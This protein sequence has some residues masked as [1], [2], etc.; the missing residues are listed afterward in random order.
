MNYYKILK[1]YRHIE[2]PRIKLLGILALHLSGRRYINVF[3]DPVLACNL[4]CQMCYFS[5]AEARKNLHGQ[6]S[7]DDL[8]ALSRSLFPYALKVQIG[9]GAEPTVSKN[10]ADII[11]LAKAEQVPYISMTTNGNLLTEEKLRELVDAGLSEITISAHGFTKETYEQLMQGAHFDLFLQLIESLKAIRKEHPDFNIRLNY[12]VNED[13]V[14]ELI[15]FSKLFKGVLPNELQIRP[16]Q[17][18]GDSSYKNFRLDKIRQGYLQWIQPVVDFCNANGITCLYPTLEN[19]SELEME[20]QKQEPQNNPAD[21][22]P[23]FHISPYEGWKEKIN[24][25]HEGFKD[26]CRRTHRVQFI[27]RSLIG[28]KEKKTENLDITKNLN[29]NVK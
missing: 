16:I 28:L 10:L 14:E 18:I 24:P 23:Y 21:E 2:S 5:D 8:T 12:T 13:N 7:L 29:Y 9:C 3:L 26:Y 27:L 25:Y 15:L 4:R 11:R 20:G 22:L 1:I 17:N 19:L 6:F